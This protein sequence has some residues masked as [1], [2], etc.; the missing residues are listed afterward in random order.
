MLGALEAKVVVTG[1]QRAMRPTD[2]DMALSANPKLR[3]K[4]L[5][6]YTLA[7]ALCTCTALLSYRELLRS[8]PLITYKLLSDSTAT[9]PFP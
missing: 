7:L 4:K 9:R 3:T 6:V 2:A 1:Y 8:G 5:T